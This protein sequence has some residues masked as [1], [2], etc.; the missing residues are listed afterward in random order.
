[1]S[2]IGER[3]AMNAVGKNS[4]TSVSSLTGQARNN[5]LTRPSTEG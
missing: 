1:M 4:I 5:C 3:S 2:V